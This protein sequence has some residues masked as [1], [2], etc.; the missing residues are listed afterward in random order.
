MHAHYPFAS[1]DT[2]DHYQVELLTIPSRQPHAI[3]RAI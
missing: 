3:D 1:E 2:P